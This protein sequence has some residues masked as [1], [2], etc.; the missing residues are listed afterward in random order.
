MDMA[1]GINE[2]FLADA[3]AEHLRNRESGE[4][5]THCLECGDPIPEK[6]RSAVPGCCRCFYCQK[7]FENYRFRR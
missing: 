5:L 7:N 3:L 1:Q 2:Q 4:S 6:R